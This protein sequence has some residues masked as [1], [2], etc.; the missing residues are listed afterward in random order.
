MKKEY[1][2]FSGEVHY[3]RIPKRNWDFV[4]EKV[5][6]ANLNTVST[7]I[8]WCIHEER[9]GDFDFGGM[10]SEEKDVIS[11]IEK[12]KNAGLRL[13]LR[14]GPVSN[15][16]LLREGVPVWL[17]K[18][19]PCI[20]AE[21]KG[22]ENL[23]H[24]TLISY[25]NKD[26]LSYVRRWYEKVLE[27]V[28]RYEE[29]PVVL[30]QL[31]NEIGMS[32]WVN[33]T[34]DLSFLTTKMYQKFLEKKYKRIEILNKIYKTNYKDFSEISQPVTAKDIRVIYDWGS[35]YREEYFPKY[36]KFLR[37]NFR[38]KSKLKILVNIP[39][40]FDY[41]TRARGF[42]SPCT[43][44]F[45]KN[46]RK[47]EDNII[48]GG[49]YQLRRIDY[50]NFHDVFIT[51]EAVN[52][53]NPER[54][55]I[56]AELQ[57]G[58][59]RDRPR[60][61]PED[62]E[63]HLK[64]ALAS[65]V[66]G[67][68]LYMFAG[69][70]NPRNFG[71]F[72]RYHDW[73]APVGYD[74]KIKDH[75]KTIK[76][77]GLFIKTWGDVL[78]KTEKVNS[79]SFGFYQPYWCG[80]FSD[81]GEL[82]YTRSRYFFDG[83]GRILLLN[84][85]HFD[86]VDVERD[87]LENVKNLFFFSWKWVDERIQRKILRFVK[88]GGY[89][90]VYPELPDLFLEYLNIKKKEG[91]GPVYFGDIECYVEGK[92]EGY[93]L[94]GSFDLIAKDKNGNVCSFIMEYGMGKILVIG[95]PFVHYF[96]FQIDILNNVLERF[97]IKKDFEVYPKDIIVSFLKSRRGSFFFFHNYHGLEFDVSFRYRS[98]SV[99]FKIYPKQIKILPYDFSLSKNLKLK[100]ATAEVINIDG[101][102]ILLRGRKGEKASVFFEA[103]G[104]RKKAIVKFRKEKVWVNLR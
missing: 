56:C 84:N 7:Y 81:F 101:N 17:F 49:A 58:V 26:F 11:F 78:L 15:A 90:I 75:F 8:P 85:Y 27:I 97:G 98:F 41:D 100:F 43:T 62:V 95:F 92:V 25:L 10:T 104:K 45:Y 59:M 86:F 103:S 73:Q 35:F 18:K 57:T 54:K 39:Q 70:K 68:N 76:D 16:E 64:T 71:M 14:I 69:G 31:D 102:R 96:D 34:P 94:K 32:H 1:Y 48:F 74:L 53:I 50:E 88:D 3:F 29:N 61:Y 79:L 93:S 65:G 12:I 20:L 55:N 67:M 28:K 44:S 66:K 33:K 9:E 13:I 23:P 24:T 63:M 40:F 22:S 2:I 52:M 4:I 36:F 87:D 5:K 47:I 60:I 72:G 51:T 89:L 19:Y 80:E 30:V 38:K 6:K 82:E 46:F 42:Y 21:G 99:D 77:F 37:E 91:R 83:L